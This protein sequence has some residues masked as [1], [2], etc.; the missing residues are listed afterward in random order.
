MNIFYLALLL[1]AAAFLLL[2]AFSIV[3]S[4]S[5]ADDREEKWDDNDGK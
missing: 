5:N 4:A 2:I 1:T 3:R